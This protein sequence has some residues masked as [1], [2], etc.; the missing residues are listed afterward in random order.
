LG[1]CCL[2]LLAPTPQ[3]IPDQGQIEELLL[4][5]ILDLETAEDAVVAA[6]DILVQVVAAAVAEDIPVQEAVVAAAEFG[7]AA[8]AGSPEQV[9]LVRDTGLAA[10]CLRWLLLVNTN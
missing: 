10:S 3:D 1:Y 6:E 5:G 9:E 4:E 7:I 2:V 8:V